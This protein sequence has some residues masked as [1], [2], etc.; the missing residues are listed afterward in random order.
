MTVGRAV[1]SEK[2]VVVACDG[3]ARCI[4]FISSSIIY[5]EHCSTAVVQLYTAYS[6][7]IGSAQLGT[8]HRTSPNYCILCIVRDGTMVLML[9]AGQRVCQ[10][11]CTTNPNKQISSM[12]I[13]LIF[14]CQR[15]VRYFWVLIL[16][17]SS[18]GWWWTM[19]TFDNYKNHH[20]LDIKYP[21][22]NVHYQYGTITQHQ[23]IRQSQFVIVLQ[24]ETRLK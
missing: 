10:L 15:I 17:L 22:M 11:L 6:D 7:E 14:S 16:T 5:N 18:S 2:C 23:T 4:Q 8:S 9:L 13:V 20:V 21:F 3:I 1:G 24:N 19:T 12:A